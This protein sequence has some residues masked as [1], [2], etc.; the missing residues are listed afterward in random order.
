M[1][2]EVGLGASPLRRVW[3]LP[4]GSTL[5]DSTTRSDISTA[6]KYSADMK[7]LALFFSCLQSRQDAFR[8]HLSTGSASL[9]SGSVDSGATSGQT[10]TS[11]THVSCSEHGR[12]SVVNLSAYL[13]SSLIAFYQPQ[14]VR[15]D[16]VSDVRSSDVNLIQM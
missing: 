9:A 16:K 10:N 13:L 6:L 5:A 15:N 14:H 1:I 7:L 11:S 2:Q 8:F 4:P 12:I 3:V